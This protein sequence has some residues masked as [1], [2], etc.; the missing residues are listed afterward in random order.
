V[1]SCEQVRALK[2]AGYLLLD[3][4]PDAATA[5][6]KERARLAAADL[7]YFNHRTQMAALHTCT[8]QHDGSP[9]GCLRPAEQ[10]SSGLPAFHRQAFRSKDGFLRTIADHYR[11][12]GCGLFGPADEAARL[13]PDTFAVGPR[14]PSA[15][16]APVKLVPAAAEG[17]SDCARFF[18]GAGAG[19][20]WML[21][22][23]Q[24][25]GGKGISVHSD[26][27]ALA[28]A[29]AEALRL[30]AGRSAAEVCTAADAQPP[31]DEQGRAPRTFVVQRY[32]D[33]LLLH[34]RKFDVRVYLLVASQ[35]PM[36]AFWRGG[37]CRRALM[38]YDAD[39]P[40]TPATAAI[41]LTNTHQQR[42]RDGYIPEDH[43]WS[44]GQLRDYI[45][46][47]RGPAALR[48]FERRW[49]AFIPAAC[50]VLLAA[51]L[52][53]A[54]VRPAGCLSLRAGG[55]GKPSLDSQRVHRE[56]VAA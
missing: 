37:Y 1:I 50:R 17:L 13:L 25:S 31:A 39:A 27:P 7:V 42:G 52:E 24:S 43:I 47:A 3:S 51:L 40:F 28:V 34:N 15:A 46:D 35:R 23:S 16:G 14:P 49:A 26:R 4:V 18:Q 41:H 10:L 5:T 45:A 19:G 21:K 22:A 20:R 36:V 53:A 29:L 33:P 8:T 48:L 32:L 56:R 55:D 11:R 30:P 12:Q 2:A 44:L 54:P 9:A 38:E 6:K